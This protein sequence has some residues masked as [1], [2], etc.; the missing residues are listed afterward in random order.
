MPS[1]LHEA[2]LQEFHTHLLFQLDKLAGS[3][4]LPIARFFQDIVSLGSRRMAWLGGDTDAALAGPE[5]ASQSSA[6]SADSS[7]A[8]T[9]AVLGARPSPDLP[10]DTIT[11]HE[12]DACYGRRRYKFPGVVVEVAYSQKAQELGEIAWNYIVESEGD[13]KMV[14]GIDIDYKGSQKA[15]F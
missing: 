3:K 4:V 8:S 2:F 15:S 12:P 7:S 13:I 1:E 10:D 6:D 5:P 9:E 14:I 11:Q